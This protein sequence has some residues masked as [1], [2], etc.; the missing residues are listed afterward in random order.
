MAGHCIYWKR[1]YNVQ[2]RRYSK[3]LPDVKWWGRSATQAMGSPPLDNLKQIYTLLAPLQLCIE[4][5]ILG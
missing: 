5:I 4:T 1:Y 3:C 2:S